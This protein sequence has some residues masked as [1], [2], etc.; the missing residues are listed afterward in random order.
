MSHGGAVIQIIYFC[1]RENN[2][3][4]VRGD[5]RYKDTKPLE[6]GHCKKAGQKTTGGGAC[7][8]WNGTCILI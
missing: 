1:F 4:H 5:G 8:Y 3:K 6:R 7:I 2:S